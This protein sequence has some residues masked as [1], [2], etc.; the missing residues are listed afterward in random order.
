MRYIYSLKPKLGTTINSLDQCSIFLDQ[1][2][3]NSLMLHCLENKIILKKHVCVL[4][5]NAWL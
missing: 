1:S 3:N 2:V 4:Q 5:Y